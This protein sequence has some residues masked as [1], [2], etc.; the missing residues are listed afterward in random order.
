MK[1][2]V[3]EKQTP[4]LSLLI[5][6]TATLFR[7]SS[8]H[9]NILIVDTPQYGKVLLLDNKFQTTDMDEFIYHEMIAHVPLYSHPAPSKV[10]VI[11]GGDGGTV[12]EVLKHQSVDLVELAEIDRDV[13][14]ASKKYFPHLSSGFSDHRCKIIIADGVT[15]IKNMAGSYDIIIVDSTDPIGPAANLFTEDFYTAAYAS[16]RANGILVSQTE[17]PFLHTDFIVKTN[18]TLSAIFPIV[19]LYLAPIPTYPSGLWSFTVG[20]KKYDPSV[21]SRKGA[22]ATKYYTPEIHKASFVLPR[23]LEDAIRTNKAI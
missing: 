13:V 10:L 9:Q 7:K 5:R 15:Y 12:R 18:R 19:R 22:I 21:P 2:W 23:F 3:T 14:E 6:T 8:N 20:S 4:D 17:S 16:L 1:L 11:G